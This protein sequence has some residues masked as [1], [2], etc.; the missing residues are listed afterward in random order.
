V[1]V[2]NNRNRKERDSRKLNGLGGVSELIDLGGVRHFGI[3]RQL[4]G[5]VT[6]ALASVS[7]TGSCLTKMAL[8]ALNVV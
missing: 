2:G 7:E 3:T 6:G 1:G 5:F 4:F 8:A